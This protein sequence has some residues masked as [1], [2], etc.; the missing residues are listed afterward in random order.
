MTRTEQELSVVRST[1]DSM[2]R[3]NLDVERLHLDIGRLRAARLSSN[4]IGIAT[5]VIMCDRHITAGEAFDVLRRAA[6]DSRR[7]LREVAE[8]VIDRGALT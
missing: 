5:G 4:R 8:E 6:R 3:L 1:H 2:A 7:R